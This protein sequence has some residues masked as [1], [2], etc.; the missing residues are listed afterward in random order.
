VRRARACRKKKPLT[1]T[2]SF[3]PCLISHCAMMAATPTTQLPL[4][5][6][7]GRFRLTVCRARSLPQRRA[8]PAWGA[9]GTQPTLVVV[10]P[11][12]ASCRSGLGHGSLNE[13]TPERCIVTARPS[14]PALRRQRGRPHAAS[15]SSAPSSTI[16]VRIGLARP[17]AGTATTRGRHGYPA[18]A[19]RIRTNPAGPRNPLRLR[20]A[21]GVRINGEHQMA[22]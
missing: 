6:W 19:S 5:V 17:P 7:S 11:K 15:T 20:A 8:V 12:S 13:R 18:R 16:S 4:R 2:D 1:L 14:A 3:Q 21:P 9:G 10:G 22:R